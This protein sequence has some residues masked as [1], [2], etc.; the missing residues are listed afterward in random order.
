MN[1]IQ[2][3]VVLVKPDG[4]RRK[5]IG[6]VI[7]RFEKVGLKV[8]ALKMVWVDSDFIGKHYPDKEDYLKSVGDKTL[9]NYLKYGYDPNESLGTNNPVEIGKLVRKWNMDM[10]GNGPLVA[11]LLEGIESVLLVRKMV[12]PTNLA[13]ALPGTIR[14]DFSSDSLMLANLEKRP[15]KTL[16]HASGS[17]EEAEFEK[18]LW[19]KEDEI[20]KY[21]MPDEEE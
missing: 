9:E 6:E 18:K 10:M 17:I 11:I 13:S 3:T 16:I 5:M 21:K 19:F 12:G 8:L 14:G 20:H 15:I 2:Q 4:V 7:S 1:F